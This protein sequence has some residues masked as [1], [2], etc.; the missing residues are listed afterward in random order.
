VVERGEVWLVALDSTIG[1]EVKKTR[2]ALIISPAELNTAL[3][4]VIVAPMT[5]AGTAAPFRLPIVFDRT[6]GLILLDQIRAVD[7]RRL[8][9]RLGRVLGKTAAAAL[10]VL[11]ELFAD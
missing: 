2:P 3:A 6:H 1:R 4:T 9:K 8:V 5:S 10:A 7:K 11:R